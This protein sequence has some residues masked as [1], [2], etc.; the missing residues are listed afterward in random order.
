MRNTTEKKKHRYKKAAYPWQE[1]DKPFFN[2]GFLKK[3][4]MIADGEPWPG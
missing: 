4:R 2:L 1:G 3:Y